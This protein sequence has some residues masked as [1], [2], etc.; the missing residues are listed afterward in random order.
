MRPTWVLCWVGVL[1]AYGL[2]SCSG[3]LPA[4]NAA[5]RGHTDANEERRTSTEFAVGKSTSELVEAGD[6]EGAVRA[7]KAALS[8]AEQAAGSD[9]LGLADA[10]DDLSV[11]YVN[12]G[13]FSQAEPLLERALALRERSL[14]DSD[15]RVAATLDRLGRLQIE[16][17]ELA[18]A[19]LQINRGLEIRRQHLPPG[20]AAIAESKQ[21]LGELYLAEGRFGEAETELRNALAI[22][23]ATAGPDSLESAAV[24]VS[25][26]RALLYAAKFG[27]AKDRIEHALSAQEH[28]AGLNHPLLGLTLYTFAELYIHLGDCGRA[29][30]PLERAAEID[31][32]SPGPPSLAAPVVFTL[33]ACYQLLGESDAARAIWPRLTKI[34]KS[35]MPAEKLI[36][37]T[38]VSLLAPALAAEFGPTYRVIPR[39][40]ELVEH[41]E[42][43]L[44]PYHPTTGRLYAAIAR[45]YGTYGDEE[46]ATEYFER[47]LLSAQ[48]SDVPDLKILTAR[49]YSEFLFQTGE[50]EMAILFGK[51]AVS[52][53]QSVR[54]KLG[55]TDSQLENAFIRNYRSDFE[56]LAGR[57]IEAGRL[58]EAQ[59]VLSM[60]KE[61]EYY[62]F[63]RRTVE[64][65]AQPGLALSPT[66]HSKFERYQTISSQIAR[67]GREYEMLRIQKKQSRHGNA[68]LE[69]AE[70]N[71]LSEL[72]ELLA[73]A[74]QQFQS[75]LLQARMDLRNSGRQ[76]ALESINLGSLRTLQDTLRL[77]GP[78][79]VLIHYLVTAERLH[80]LVTTSG[81]Q[82]SRSVEVSASDLNALIHRVRVALRDPD[83]DPRPAAAELYHLIFQPIRIDLDTAGA[84]HLMI[85]LD[86]ALRY[87]PFAAL[88]DPFRSR[89]LAEDFTFSLYAEATRNTLEREVP[90]VLEVAGFGVQQAT[91]ESSGLPEV[92]RELESIVLTDPGDSDG[93]MNGVIYMDDA[94]TYESLVDSL[95]SGFEVI[96]IASHFKFNAGTVRD[97]YLLLG[98]GQTVTLGEL[99]ARDVSFD[100][101]HLLTLSACDTAVG[102]T[103]DGREIEGLAMLALMQGAKSVVASLW[104]VSDHSTAIFMESFYRAAMGAGRQSK[105]E[106]M[107]LAQLALLHGRFSTTAGP[108]GQID[109]RYRHPY[110]WA[111][112]ILIGNWR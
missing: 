49:L 5:R 29:V 51:L 18:K 61:N 80:L 34:S 24:S 56:V 84:N 99:R 19:G 93:V 86:G 10:L 7:A 23:D 8:R 16:T 63:I 1:A 54:S 3:T 6:F 50:P 77:L 85:S 57:L 81:T 76:Q 90:A 59:A 98:G 9:P 95:E 64:E 26:A 106:A 42:E 69:R 55:E 67:L 40:R 105:A 102:A 65:G 45:L 73:V 20:S 27:E 12:L 88:Y 22:R 11:A 60:L 30:I 72:R 52:E 108:V 25:L 94:F 58:A 110:Y 75:A 14:G 71:R 43:E 78:D 13:T 32:Q 37:M 91:A 44:G 39:I 38:R 103:G 47:A 70:A 66:E 15:L 111:P 87:I 82:F 21:S 2:F 17:G 28:S 36:T 48:S 41:L 4:E 68:P 46:E 31:V 53:I 62:E 79:V 112:F 74:R 92:M 109:T 107:R 100:A 35:L 104:Q 101:V 33:W 83:R 96:H 89:Y 97:S